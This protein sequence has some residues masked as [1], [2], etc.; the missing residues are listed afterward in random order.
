MKKLIIILI[1]LISAPVYGQRDETLLGKDLEFGGFGGVVVKMSEIYDGDSGVFVGGRGGWIINRKFF[2]GG[3]GYGLV[4]RVNASP[5]GFD[6]IEYVT[7]EKF[8][9]MMGYG[10]LEIGIISNT[11]KLLHNESYILLGAGGVTYG[12]RFRDF[13]NDYRNDAFFVIEPATNLIVNVTDFMRLGAGVSYRF[14]TGVD[15][16][17]LENSHLDGIS[18]N[19]TVKFGS[20]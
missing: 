7:R 12:D 15:V 8:R 9:L 6:F 10:G 5:F 19:F 2:I 4:N 14:I 3:G 20:F 18:V 11:H 13:V 16:S 1:C 17:G